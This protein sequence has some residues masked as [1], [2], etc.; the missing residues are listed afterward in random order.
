MNLEEMLEY[1]DPLIVEI[2]EE[3]GKSNATGT[4][5]CPAKGCDGTVYYRVVAYNGHTA[6]SCSR[7]ECI[8]WME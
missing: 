4:K 6:G 1:V 2:K 8:A 3:H 5:P 7:K